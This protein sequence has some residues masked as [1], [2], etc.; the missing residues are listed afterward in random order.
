MSRFADVTSDT[1]H[2]P[3]PVPE[4]HIDTDDTAP[5]RRVP[6]QGA[7]Q[8]APRWVIWGG[9]GVAAA[10][11]T[12]FGILAARAVVDTISGNDDD[13]KARQ[14]RRQAA[15]YARTEA[16]ERYPKRPHTYRED[17]DDDRRT[18]G[19]RPARPRRRKPEPER[20]FL[21]DFA[22][23]A[24]QL[25]TNITGLVVAANAAVNGFQQ[26]SGK[27]DGII[28]DFLNAADNVGEVWGN[29]KSGSDDSAKSAPSGEAAPKPG[30]DDIRTH[31][32]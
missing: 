28:R 17:N 32:L 31:R 11:T 23:S 10:A 26:V 8:R 27:A 6:P 7:G 13:G 16:E 19:T 2:G 3:R 5:R 21:A 18:E 1:P 15:R 25:A 9:V 22:E 12:A 29:R 20:S 30:P 24:G 14:P 4:G